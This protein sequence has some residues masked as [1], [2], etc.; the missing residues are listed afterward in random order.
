MSCNVISAFTE[1]LARTAHIEKLEEGGFVATV[2]SVTGL[3]ASGDTLDECVHDLLA[4]I[5]RWA[6][7]ALARGWT[8]PIVGKTDLN[9]PMVRGLALNHHSMPASETVWHI[10]TDDEFV[11]RLAAAS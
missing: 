10:Y 9:D 8:F 4:A 7:K 6:T 1:E 11:K 3:V 2:P 5:Q